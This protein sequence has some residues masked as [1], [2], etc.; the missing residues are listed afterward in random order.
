MLDLMFFSPAVSDHCGLDRERRVFGDFES[1]GSGGQ[2]GHAAHLAQFQGRLHI[3]GIKNV[4][5]SDAV[6]PVLRDE[7]L[8]AD[9]N[10]PQARGH[11]VT[12]GNFNSAADY[13]HKALIVAAIGEHF[14]YTVSGVFRAAVDAEDAHGGSVAGEQLALSFQLHPDA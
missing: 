8:Q 3:N 14:D 13:T 12:S 5:E 6:G 11:R 1:G 9:R 4:F 10:A 2:H 7:F